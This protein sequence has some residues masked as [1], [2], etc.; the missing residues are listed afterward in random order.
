[1]ALLHLDANVSLIYN[2]AVHY[3]NLRGE[4][5]REGLDD[6]ERRKRARERGDDDDEND[7]HS[8]RKKSKKSKHRSRAERH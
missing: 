4:E 3:L 8:A 6:L 7:G 2:F 5:I 1:M